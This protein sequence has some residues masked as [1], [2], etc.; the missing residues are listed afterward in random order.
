MTRMVQPSETLYA[1][2]VEERLAHTDDPAFNAN[3]ATRSPIVFQVEDR[4][5][6]WMAPLSRLLVPAVKVLVAIAMLGGAI[7]GCGNADTTQTVAQTESEGQVEGSTMQRCVAL[8]NKGSFA[9][10]NGRKYVTQSVLGRTEG[11]AMVVEDPSGICVVG[12]DELAGT[13]AREAS[14]IAYAWSFERGNWD[15]Y[16][17]INHEEA[18]LDPAEAEAQRP[19]VN[20][21]VALMEA[22]NEAVRSEPNALLE[23]DGHLVLVNGADSSIETPAPE[24]DPPEY[25]QGQESSNTCDP[26]PFQPGSDAAAAGI[27]IGGGATCAE[28]TELLKA[29]AADGYEGDP[30]DYECESIPTTTGMAGTVNHCVD[31]EKVLEFTSY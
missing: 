24:E 8:W 12:F 7:G 30:G 3:V 2:V 14:G 4:L 11:Q 21:R 18:P 28:V 16:I 23:P 1:A 20:G 22:M 10:Y 27:T 26:V 17:S 25:E 31:G 13:S 15:L 29:W 5:L 9:Q 19:E 6:P